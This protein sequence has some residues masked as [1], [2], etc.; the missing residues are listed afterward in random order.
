[1]SYKSFENSPIF[2][3]SFARGGS[4]ML[5]NMLRSHPEICS[6]TGELQEVVL[7]KK[8]THE[9]PIRII[10]KRLRSRELRRSLGKEFFSISN[11]C[12]RNNTLNMSLVNKLIDIFDYEK[13]RA[14]SETQNK[15]KSDGLL[16]TSDE[17]L[18]S[19]TLVKLLNG[20]IFSS[21]VFCKTFPNADFI[22]LIRNPYAV[23]EGHVRRGYD[24]ESICHNVNNSLLEINK[25]NIKYNKFNIIK[26]E[27]LIINPK[28]TLE[29]VFNLC[30][31]DASSLDKIRHV[32]KR[33]M[34]KDGKR[35]NNNER[36]IQRF[37]PNHYQSLEWNPLSDYG[38]SFF[39]DINENQIKNLSSQQIETI[40][41]ICSESIGIFDY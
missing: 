35:K 21:E 32:E 19:R 34:R 20:L 5:L 14:T 13:L 2:L 7:G 18:R 28:N 11:W 26:F 24:L 22:A 6:P 41:S 37:L 4:S 1:M 40:G 25:L 17:I 33:S 9:S 27:D 30:N 36:F 10:D 39:A 29:E 23:I 12:K 38:K 8:I 3:V 31:I 16:Y 15:Y